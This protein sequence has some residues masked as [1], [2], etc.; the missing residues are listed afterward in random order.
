MK[1]KAPNDFALFLKTGSTFQFTFA[2]TVTQGT[3]DTAPRHKA[4]LWNAETQTRVGLL[5]SGTE[6]GASPAVPQARE[7]P[8]AA[9]VQTGPQVPVRGGRRAPHAPAQPGL[10]PTRSRSSPAGGTRG[11]PH[12]RPCPRRTRRHRGS[13]PRPLLTPSP[14]YRASPSPPHPRLRHR[15]R[16]PRTALPRPLPSPR[17]PGAV[18]APCP[19]S[20]AGGTAPADAAAHPAAA[21]GPRH[22][23][24]APRQPRPLSRGALPAGAS[25]AGL[26][27]CWGRCRRRRPSAA[28]LPPPQ[29]CGGAAHAPPHSAADGAAQGAGR[30]RRSRAAPRGQRRTRHRDLPGT[31]PGPASPSPS[32]PRWGRAHPRVP[33]LGREERWN[34][35]PA[36]SP[37]GAAGAAAAPGS[38]ARGPTRP[39]P[40]EAPRPRRGERSRGGTGHRPGAAARSRG[41]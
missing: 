13:L 38:A 16:G 34:L 11:T 1:R 33:R 22:R 8:V 24:L 4:D 10:S 36:R 25:P 35:P 12:P 15:L 14:G 31:L 32:P 2:T 28:S 39:R 27:R 40:A 26:S 29:R 3:Q 19:R 6:P 17:S 7:A 30:A 9:P 5:W 21:G 23:A 37:A 20:G 41:G 18:P